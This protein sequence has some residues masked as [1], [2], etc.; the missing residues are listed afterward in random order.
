MPLDVREPGAARLRIGGTSEGLRARRGGRPWRGAVFAGQRINL[1]VPFDVVRWQGRRLVRG[2]HRGRSR[3]ERR[4]FG[5]DASGAVGS[6]RRSGPPEGWGLRL[7]LQGPPS[8]SGRHARGALRGGE[9]RREGYRVKRVAHYRSG[10]WQRD[11][12][13]VAR[14]PSSDWTSASHGAV[15]VRSPAT[16]SRA[17][18]STGAE[19]WSRPRD[20]GETG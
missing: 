1:W 14:P 5:V 10:V 11:T 13:P 16:E 9:N 12:P 2:P 18:R 17:C 20:A 15:L 7:V 19:A 8:G 3:S 6:C 4:P